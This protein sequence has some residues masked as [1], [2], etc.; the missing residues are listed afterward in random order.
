MRALGIIPARGGSK[1]LPGK[2]LAPLAGKPLIAF[3]L[4]ASRR[5]QRLSKVIVSTDD[6]AIAAVAQEL[7]GD[8]PFLRPPELARDDTPTLPVL[9]H[10]V[11]WLRAAGEEFEIVVTLQPTSPLRLP[12][13]ID[14]AIEKLVASGADSVVSVCAAEH[15]PFWYQRLEGD[16]LAPLF[17][18]SMGQSRRQDLPQVYRLNGAVYA[19]R[20]R[21]IMDEDRSWGADTRALVM[22][23]EF[24]VDIDS[25][26]DLFT[27]EVI[28]R[29]YRD[30]FC[31]D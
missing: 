25:K 4:E 10:A 8:V 20:T 12:R 16:R 14:A 19:S 1:G 7:G 28:L 30:A 9:Q 23:P 17:G 6:P 18:E 21:V 13:H 29:E 15:N 31:T 2:N 24:S 27:A 26:L 22:E 5:A 11:H 3:T